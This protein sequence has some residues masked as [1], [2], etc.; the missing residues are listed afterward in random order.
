MA[1][2]LARPGWSDALIACKDVNELPCQ[3]H[4]TWCQLSYIAYFECSSH[5]RLRLYRNMFMITRRL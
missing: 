4:Q 3:Q 2:L 5:M 1:A